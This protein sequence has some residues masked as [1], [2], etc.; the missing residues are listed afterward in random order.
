MDQGH[1]FPVRQHRN[2]RSFGFEI[3]LLICCFF[4]P[5]VLPTISL[6]LTTISFSVA[7][8]LPNFI[9]CEIC[10]WNSESWGEWEKGVTSNNK[11]NSPVSAQ[12]AVRTISFY[13]GAQASGAA[14]TQVKPRE[15]G[16]LSISGNSAG[17]ES[18]AGDNTNMH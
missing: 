14:V 2:K 16:A 4:A 6:T 12:T 17:F 11:E 1:R 10:V 13:P 15:A 3:I 9:D 5:S 18:S 8:D 7:Q